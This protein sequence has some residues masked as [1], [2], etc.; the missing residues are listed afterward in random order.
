MAN[1]FQSASSLISKEAQLQSS[2]FKSRVFKYYCSPPP[3]P[4]LQQLPSQAYVADGKM[5]C[6]VSKLRLSSNLVEAAHILP[7]ASAQWGNCA[8]G[9]CDVWDERN[10]LL[11]AE[12]FEKVMPGAS[13]THLW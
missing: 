1:P 12:P 13:A 7:K 4:G 11:W 9:V 5:T 2:D 6:M 8:L 10:G 3:P